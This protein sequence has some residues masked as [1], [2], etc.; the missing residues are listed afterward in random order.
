MPDRNS[1]VEVVE[2]GDIVHL[3]NGSHRFEYVEPIVTDDG[4][5]ILFIKLLDPPMGVNSVTRKVDPYRV[6]LAEKK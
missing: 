2:P 6:S 1:K 3:D 4:R 5:T